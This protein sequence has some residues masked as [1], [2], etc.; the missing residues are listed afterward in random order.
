MLKLEPWRRNLFAIAFSQFVAL[1]AANLVFPFIPFY[2]EDLG[3]TDKGQI[4]L[5]SGFMGTATGVTLF[6]FS[7][8]WGTLADR[9][10]RKPMLL[11]AYLGATVTM[12]LQGLARNV[13]QL[14]A[15]RALQGAFSGTIPAATAL[16]AAGTP[17]ERVAFG[18]G[19]VQM[20]LFSSQFVGP[21]VGGTLAASIGFRPTFIAVGIFFLISFFLV[22]FM[23]EEHFERPAKEERTGF[24]ENIRTVVDRR[25]LLILIG[26]VFFMNAGPAFVRPVIPLVVESFDSMTSAEVLSGFAF[27]ALALTSAIAALSV[28]RISDRVGARNALALTTMGAGIAYVPVAIATNVPS[29]LLLMAVVGLFSGGML[30][31]VNSLIDAWSPPGKQASAFG[32]TGSAMALAFSVAPLSGGAVAAAAGVG[33]S[34]LVI[35]LVMIV[36]GAGVL[37][38][39]K[40]PPREEPAEAPSGAGE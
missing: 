15:L 25:P 35:G 6:I 31:I 16:V 8:I 40:E 19:V 10:G 11:R 24:V 5:W 14:A 21:L 30:P 12:T 27:A 20:A 26:I 18:L 33:T 1:G 32:L 28:S 36:V 7:P 9:F 2:V 37:V 39:V 29:F 17:K 13:W 4:A 23:V 3:V 34:F 22:L 38:V